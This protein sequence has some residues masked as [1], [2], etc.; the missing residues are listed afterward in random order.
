MIFK[1]ITVFGT[2]SFGARIA[3][4][5]AF[6]KVDVTVYDRDYGLLEEARTKF[7]EM[8][9]RYL[10][11]FN[12]TSENVE[13]AMAHIAYSMD[14]TEAVGNAQLVIEAVTEDLGVKKKIY[15]QLRQTAPQNALFATTT[16][17]LDPEELSRAL[18]RPDKFVV[19]HLT[20]Q[21]DKTDSAEVI[22][23]SSTDPQILEKVAAFIQEAGMEV[24]TIK[25]TS[26][27]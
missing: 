16:T 20:G 11:Q 17:S 26:E 18:G 10:E 12:T 5:L 1:K 7:R 23:L 13:A 14:L 9:D 15:N 3:F 6:N 2:G 19:F 8:G 4:H 22:G 25:M 21:K 27:I 24:T